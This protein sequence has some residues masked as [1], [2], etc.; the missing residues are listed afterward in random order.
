MFRRGSLYRRSPKAGYTD[1]GQPAA[2]CFLWES[3]YK[4]NTQ[5]RKQILMHYIHLALHIPRH[6]HCFPFHIRD[7]LQHKG[8]TIISLTK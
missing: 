7:I 5:T 8:R 2:K 1:K 3:P 4:D 6:L